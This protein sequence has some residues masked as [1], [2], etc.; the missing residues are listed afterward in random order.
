MIVHFYIV[1]LRWRPPKVLI[2]EES[3]SRNLSVLLPNTIVEAR[4]DQIRRLV[5]NHCPSHHIDFYIFL[6]AVVC[7]ICSAIFTFIARSLNI[8]MWCPLILL[9]VPTGLS[10]WT[11]KRRSTLIVKIKEFE[12]RLKK[13]LYEFN[14]NDSNHHINWSLERVPIEQAPCR[15][16][17]FCLMI[18]ITE[19]DPEMG[20]Y[21]EELPT[22]QVATN[23]IILPPSYELALIRE[24]EPAVIL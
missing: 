11:S 22:Y 3:L 8:S 10:F 20:I 6:L 13:T 19:L 1:S 18:H 5:R 2:D 15:S 7:I 4:I 17:R 24:P 21:G 12:S 16:A 9:L 23:N 14:T